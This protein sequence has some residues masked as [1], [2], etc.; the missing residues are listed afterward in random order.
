MIGALG[1]M[2]VVT[3]L[4]KTMGNLKSAFGELLDKLYANRHT[5]VWALL[6][7]P[8]WMRIEDVCLA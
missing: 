2:R 7:R 6:F 4:M 5:Q 3:G 8:N 1:P